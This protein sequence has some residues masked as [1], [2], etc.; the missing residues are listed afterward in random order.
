LGGRRGY[1][2]ATRK[3]NVLDPAGRTVSI[4]ENDLSIDHFVAIKNMLDPRLIRGVD[5]LSLQEVEQFIQDRVPG[6]H[7]G[8]LQ[9]M[10]LGV[11]NS[12]NDRMAAMMDS[13]KDHDGQRVRLNPSQ[14]AALRKR[15]GLILETMREWVRD[16]TRGR[17]NSP[18]ARVRRVNT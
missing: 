11:N 5:K 12:K 3:Y 6:K 18:D 1:D 7:F 17:T 14:Q 10:H 13:F 2:K 16:T 4:D 15:E 8:N 9:V